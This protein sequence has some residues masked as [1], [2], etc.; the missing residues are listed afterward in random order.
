MIDSDGDGVPDE[1]DLCPG[2]PPGFK[3]DEHGCVDLKQ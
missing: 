3:V 2:N 1:L